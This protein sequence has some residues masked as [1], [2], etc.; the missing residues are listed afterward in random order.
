MVLC[1]LIFFQLDSA[2]L[3]SM[4]R[5]RNNSKVVILNIISGR[6]FETDKKQNYSRKCRVYKGNGEFTFK[7]V[8]YL[9]HVYLNP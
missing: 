6:H 9:T 7:I 2:T 3:T 8:Y 1:K 4:R 5:K